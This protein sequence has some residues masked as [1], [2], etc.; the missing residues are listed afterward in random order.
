MVLTLLFVDFGDIG[1]NIDYKGCYQMTQALTKVP[2][3]G[4]PLLLDGVKG[5]IEKVE[6]RKVTK[7]IRKANLFAL[8]CKAVREVGDRAQGFIPWNTYYG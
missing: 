5:G 2:I 7:K 6:F 4:L 1:K 8:H 3:M